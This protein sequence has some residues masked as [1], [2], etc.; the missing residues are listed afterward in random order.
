MVCPKKEHRGH[1]VMEAQ[2]GKDRVVEA[3]GREVSVGNR[4]QLGPQKQF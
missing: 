1:E 4:A 3:E 2:G